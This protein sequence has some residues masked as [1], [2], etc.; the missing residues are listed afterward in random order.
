[1]EKKLKYPKSCVGCKAIRRNIECYIADAIEQ[2]LIDNCPCWNC[3]V[4]VVCFGEDCKQYQDLNI[5]CWAYKF[6]KWL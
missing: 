5:E 2:K 3:L 6:D 1:M 4:Q